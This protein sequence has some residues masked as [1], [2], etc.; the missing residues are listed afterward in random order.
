MM[1]IRKTASMVCTGLI[2]LFVIA[3]IIGIWGVNHIRFGGELHRKNVELQDFT[4]DTRPPPAYLVEAFALA[5]VMGIHADSYA[6]NDKRLAA[7]ERQWRER[8]QYWANSADLPANL[9]AGLAETSQQEGVQFW[10][11]VNERLK[12]AARNRDKAAIDASL[13]R[14]IWIYRAHRKKTDAI[15]AQTTPAEEA[16]A[17]DSASMVATIVAVLTVGLLAVLG[18]IGAVYFGL[19][20]KVLRPLDDTANTMRAMAGGNLEAGITQ[21]HRHDEI[22]VM[23]SAIEEFRVSLKADRARSAAQRHVV[24]T[25]NAALERLSAGDLT[26]RVDDSVNGEYAGLR[27]GFNSSAD[28]LEQMLAAVRDAA[29]GVRTSAD[30]IRVASEDLA[31]RNEQQAANLEETAASVGAVTTLTRKS[32]QNAQD[33]KLAVEQTQAQAIEGGAVVQQAV[34]AMSAIERSAAEINQIIDLIDG[35]AFQTNLLALNAGV[36]AARAGEAGKGFAVVAEEV[37]ALARRSADAARD[38]KLLIANSSTQVGSGVS[39]VGQTGTLL[40][41]IV[42]QITTVTGQINANADMAASQAGNLD[43]VNVAVG[44]IDKMTQQNAAMVEEATAAARNLSSEAERLGELVAQF[45]L[46]HNSAVVGGQVA[47]ADSQRR[48]RAAPVRVTGNLALK[49]M[50][51]EDDWSD[52]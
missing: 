26:H 41:E 14:L 40:S 45:R 43:Q 51:D 39:L 49:P 22:G 18:A 11:E 42:T 5:N 2:A 10:K 44:A 52:F 32:A 46:R 21:V 33:A 36:E 6:V 19:A 20:R 25:L 37:R 4:A 3:A 47:R 48:T 17:A 27:D 30:E 24:D 12:P 15:I 9:K 38:I 1:T 8:T 35:I 7:L 16:L 23:T 28:Q 29:H 13:D 50:P 31:L 34:E